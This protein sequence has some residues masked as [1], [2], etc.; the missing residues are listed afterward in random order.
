MGRIRNKIIKRAAK[1]I[2]EKYYM[3]L[4][5]D[6]HFNKRVTED[7]AVIRTKRLKNKVAGYITVLMKRIQHGHVKG[8]YIKKH[9]EERER[10]ENFIPSKGILDELTIDVD[11]T[12]KRMIDE[13]AFTGN[14]NVVA[15]KLEKEED[16]PTKE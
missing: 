4:D 5:T 8:I 10:K 11:S 9:E 16:K 12:T 3:K 6:F 7:V 2:V 13:Y 14:F 1:Q 15:I